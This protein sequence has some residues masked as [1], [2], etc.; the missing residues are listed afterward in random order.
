MDG[1]DPEW[2]HMDGPD[3]EW[4]HM[5]GPDP[6]WGASFCCTKFF[7]HDT[8]TITQQWSADN[9]KCYTDMQAI[10]NCM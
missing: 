5:D 10:Q 4:G 6:E 1:P 3:P 8:P 9:T 7:H 2:G